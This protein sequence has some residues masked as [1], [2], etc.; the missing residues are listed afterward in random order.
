MC[1]PNVNTWHK[2]GRMALMEK[3]DV[4]INIIFFNYT[5]FNFEKSGLFLMSIFLP[6]LEEIQL[7]EL[8]KIYQYKKKEQWL[9]WDRMF[10]GLVIS[11]S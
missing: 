6:A 1:L 10:K 7:I 2:D 5:F 3:K 9:T 4:C 11:S 8:K